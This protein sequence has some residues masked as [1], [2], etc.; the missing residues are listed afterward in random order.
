MSSYVII[1]SAVLLPLELNTP[2]LDSLPSLYAYFVTF[3][4]F[5]SLLV[6]SFP[7]PLSC[8]TTEYAPVV[9]VIGSIS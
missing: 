9:R 2:F 1:S 5:R 8:P 6:A 4:V 7:F 3:P